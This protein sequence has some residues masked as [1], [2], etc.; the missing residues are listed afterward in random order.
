MVDKKNVF[1]VGDIAAEA[2]AFDNRISSRVAAGFVPDLRRAIKCEHF[3]KSFW[4]DPQFIQLYVGRI[5]EGYLELL[6]NYC[7]PKQRILDVGCG[8]GYVSLELARN[9]HKV[10]AI[11]ISEANIQIARQTL[12]DNPFVEGFGT[13]SYK[14]IPF[15]EVEG[16][17]D[18]I[19]F[20]V[21]LHHMPDVEGVVRRAMDLLCA[22]GYILCYEPC[23][24]RFREQD[25]AQVGLMRALLALTGNWYDPD[26]ILPHLKS[27]S[28]LSNYISGVQVEYVLER[29][30]SEPEG[31]SPHDLEADGETML[32]ALRKY[33]DEIVYRPGFSFIYRLLGGIR[34]PDSRIKALADFFATYD[35]L[36]VD[37]YGLSP[38]HF[39]YL[40]KKK[41]KS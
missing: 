22:G 36:A 9:G 24:E 39:Y 25:A 41:E 28:S 35:R 29:D 30:P 3:Y 20:S 40:G 21:S 34:G 6:S 15:H 13:L 11:D 12:D 38:N 7:G 2:A 14:H 37:K 18:V 33:S 32:S 4:R 1:E 19:L 23:H 31:Q 17:Y 5:V 16:I 26:E 27:E 8:A 10:I